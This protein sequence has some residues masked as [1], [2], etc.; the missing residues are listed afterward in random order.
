MKLQ[1]VLQLRAPALTALVIALTAC[2]GGSDNND[3][4]VGWQSDGNVKL[5]F[6]AFNGAAPINCNS[7]SIEL[8]PQRSRVR[9]K[10][11]RF[12][13][14]DV[15]LIRVDGT[16]Q[17]LTLARTD[18]YNVTQGGHGVSLVDLEQQGQGLCTNGSPVLNA[19]IEGSVPPGRYTGVE[20]TLGVPL[21]LNHLDS[22]GASTPRA[23]RSD[24]HPG[25][26][27]NWR[28]GMKFTKFEFEHD[29]V[30]GA[31]TDVLLH[32]GSTGCVG[33][34]VNGQPITSC[35]APNR[36]PVTLAEFNPA[37]QRVAVDAGA[38]FNYD[39]RPEGQNRCMAGPAD[40]AC[41]ASFDVLGLSWSADGS[42]T[43]LPVA[44][45]Q[46]FKGVPL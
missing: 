19:T 26:A 5:Q 38:L 33:D 25:M 46:L 41:A 40:T 7:G 44:E 29:P 21:E 28:G 17:A 39:F 12:Y 18:D 4:S 32:L 45:Q 42:G 30:E 10:D 14:S 11:F 43:G 3:S 22:L 13:V 16:T 24:I 34:P 20:M 9:L 23:L 8:G 2:G 1:S 27:W 15:K 6:A 35:K 37:E 36:V 31:G